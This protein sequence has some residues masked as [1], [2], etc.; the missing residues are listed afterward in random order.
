MRALRFD[1]TIINEIQ[2]DFWVRADSVRLDQVFVN[3]L[4]NC[5]DFCGSGTTVTISPVTDR[6]KSKYAVVM[7]RDNGPGMT[8]EVLANVFNPF[9]TTK[10]AGKGIGMGLAICYKVMEE[11]NG[12]IDIA[13]EVGNGTTVR[14]EIPRDS[15]TVSGGKQ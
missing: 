11:L 9:F 5:I 3:L 6:K 12:R 13:S 10:E 1:I 14:L 2:E 8:E 7:V 4:T 15:E